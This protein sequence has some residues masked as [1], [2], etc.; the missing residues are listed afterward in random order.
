M[1]TNISEDNSQFSINKRRPLSIIRHVIGGLIFAALFALIFAVLVKL[2]WNGIM[3]A[4]FDLGTISFW[5]AFGIIL[6][7]KMIFGGIGPRYNHYHPRRIYYYSKDRR[8]L[9]KWIRNNYRFDDD[10]LNSM[11]RRKK[12][13]YYKQYWRNE[14]KAAFEAY[15][16]K[17]EGESKH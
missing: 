10:E 11:S 12:W 6:L 7:A 9:Y 2:L 16:K 1:N 17:I 4:V 5:Q 13:E 14:G 3:P 8:Y 15:I